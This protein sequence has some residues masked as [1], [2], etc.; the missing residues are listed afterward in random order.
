ML[1]SSEP[2]ME[3]VSAKI[4]RKCKQ[5]PLVPIGIAMTSGAL[6][7]AGRALRQGQSRLANKMFVWRV[8]FQA[9][10]VAALVGGGFYYGRNPTH[11][12]RQTALMN[13]AKE[14]EQLWIQ[15]LERIDEEQKEREERSRRFREAKK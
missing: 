10:T 3:K 14:R 1:P 9:F 6:Y 15:E 11:V 5:Q 13:T 4:A 12:D 2:E 7:L 8:V